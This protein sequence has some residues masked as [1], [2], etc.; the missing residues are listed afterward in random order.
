MYLL[1]LTVLPAA[2]FHFSLGKYG[3]RIK[4]SCAISF[5]EILW[6]A[7]KKTKQNKEREKQDIPGPSPGPSVSEG[8]EWGPAAPF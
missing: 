1:L 3:S 8:L 5:P 7:F 2:P 4:F 6:G